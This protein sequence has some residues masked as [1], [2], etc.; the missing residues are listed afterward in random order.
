MALEFRAKF[1]GADS[2]PGF[3]A[4]REIFAALFERN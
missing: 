3:W 1:P 4:S 2:E